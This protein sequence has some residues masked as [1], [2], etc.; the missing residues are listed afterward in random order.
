MNQPQYAPQPQYSQPQNAPQPQYGAPPPVGIDP[1]SGKVSP[2]HA[3]ATLRIAPAVSLS[4]PFWQPYWVD[5]YT[6]QSVWTPPQQM[7]GQR[8]L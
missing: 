8:A 4:H 2:A 6:G 1:A 7:Q 5:P 3:R